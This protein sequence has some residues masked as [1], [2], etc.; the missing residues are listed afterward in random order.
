LDNSLPTNLARLLA[1]YGSVENM[2]ADIF[3]KKISSAEA[4][5]GAQEIYRRYEYLAEA[6]T[7]AGYL[8]LEA[9]RKRTSSENVAIIL[10]ISRRSI[11]E[12]KQGGKIERD[13]TVQ[14]SASDEA[15]KNFLRT[16]A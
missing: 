1:L 6:Q 4:Q 9:F 14:L 5:S 7:A 12:A 15:F 10:G 13:K 16:L 11:S 8:S 2:R 3:T